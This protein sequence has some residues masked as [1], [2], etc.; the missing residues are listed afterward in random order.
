M[1]DDAK[2]YYDVN[3]VNETRNE[4]YKRLAKLGGTVGVDEVE[5]LEL[6]WVND[7]PAADGSLN[8]GNKVTVDLKVLVKFNRKRGIHVT[9]TVLFDGIEEGGISSGF[10]GEE[11][12][13]WFEKNVV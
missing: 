2:S 5:L 6:L 12:K 11:W 3:L 10:S 8:V 9:P 7:K 1:F 4:T 13:E